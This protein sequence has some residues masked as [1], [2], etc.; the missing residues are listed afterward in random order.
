MVPNKDSDDSN[1]IVVNQSGAFDA[2]NKTT[3]LYLPIRSWLCDEQVQQQLEEK[4]AVMG[5]E[6][7]SQKLASVVMIQND[8]FIS[9][10]A[11]QEKL[12]IILSR[13]IRNMFGIIVLFFASVLVFLVR[14]FQKKKLLTLQM[15][16]RK[17]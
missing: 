4:R 1:V 14:Y 16:F 12:D 6:V 11:Y 9:Q 15:L 3:Q 7:K 5:S 10:Y 13:C 8:S 2:L 17:Q